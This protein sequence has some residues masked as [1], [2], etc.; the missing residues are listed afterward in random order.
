MIDELKSFEVISERLSN[1]QKSLDGLC[2]LVKSLQTVQNKLALDIEK[3]KTENSEAT[4]KAIENEA[5]KL[6]DYTRIIKKRVEDLEKW[7]WTTV[8]IAGTMSFIIPL[9]INLVG[10]ARK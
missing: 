8:G 4:R 2:E 5:S 10:M 3:S 9:I 7:R 6:W 1:V